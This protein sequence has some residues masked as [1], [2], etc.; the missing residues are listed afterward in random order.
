MQI[1]FRE[2]NKCKLNTLRDECSD[3]SRL[4]VQKLLTK[5]CSNTTE[6][7]NVKILMITVSV[8]NVLKF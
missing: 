2:I 1:S 8:Y 6:V 7:M 5:I 3:I 4:C